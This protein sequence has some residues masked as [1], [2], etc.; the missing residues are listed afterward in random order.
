MEITDVPHLIIMIIITLA[1]AKVAALLSNKI[2]M[3]AL[4]GWVIIGIVFAYPFIGDTNSV[5]GLLKIN[6]NSVSGS[7][8]SLCDIMGKISEVGIVFF[9]FSIG[10]KTL[11]KDL[12]SV[13][14]TAFTVA[15][16]GVLFPF[17]L[18]YFFVKLFYDSNGD[19]ALF[20]AA[21]M[22][23]TSVGVTAYIIQNLHLFHTKEAKI[24]IG[25]AIIDD[26]LGMIILAFV[27]YNANPGTSDLDNICSYTVLLILTLLLSICIIIPYIQKIIRKNNRTKFVPL[28]FSIAFCIILAFITEKLHLTSIIGSFIAGLILSKYAESW[29]LNKKIELIA[30]CVIPFFFINIGLNTNIS[31]INNQ[32]LLIIFIV[33]LLATIGKYF[34]CLLGAKLSD[35][36]MSIGSA[37][38]VSIGMIPRGEVGILV[39]SIGLSIVMNDGEHAMPSELCTAVIFMSVITTLIASPLLSIAFKKKYKDDI[40]LKE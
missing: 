24:I 23:A 22:V 32:T 2:G 20:L 15:F 18:G 25:A 29:E 13:G 19:H 27:S 14:K 5:A 31:N 34:G 8:G 30:S 17:S 36:S 28:A 40:N 11:I 21:S 1:C 26:I 37:N 39:A 33:V 4:I 3:P 12:M 9:I 7:E 38:I 35:K 6:V 16:F 10:L